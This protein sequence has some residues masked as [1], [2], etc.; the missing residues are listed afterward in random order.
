MAF[1]KRELGPIE[2]FENALKEKLAARQ[3]LA[4]RLSFTEAELSEKRTAA[5]QLAVAGAAS[6]RAQ[7]IGGANTLCLHR[8]VWEAESTDPEGVR[9]PLEWRGIDLA[10]ASIAAAS[11]GAR[12]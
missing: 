11:S 3:K 4:D 1:F 5:E 8:G 10:Q 12:S 7:A 2:R 9:L 6:P